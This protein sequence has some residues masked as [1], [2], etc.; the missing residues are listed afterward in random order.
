MSA[1]L[2]LVI[3]ES[4]EMPHFSQKVLVDKFAHK[5]TLTYVYFLKHGRPSFAYITYLSKYQHR[6]FIPKAR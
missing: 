6:K 1:F 4:S 2:I 5:E 3:G